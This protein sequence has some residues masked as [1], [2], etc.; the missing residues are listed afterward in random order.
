MW[1][2]ALNSNR[3]LYETVTM[4]V[5][6]VKCPLITCI[7]WKLSCIKH[8]RNIWDPSSL[9]NDVIFNCGLTYCVAIVC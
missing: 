2:L 5:N 6:S 4:G 3:L 9:H 1:K 8:N 7:T